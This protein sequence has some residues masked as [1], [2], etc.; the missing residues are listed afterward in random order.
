MEL[1]WDL[2]NLFSNTDAFY[3]EIEL[4]KES[5]QNISHYKDKIL[6]A[7]S[8]FE[9]L[10]QSWGIKRRAN[11]ILVYGS[12]R[13]YK[14]VHSEECIQMKKVAESLFNQINLTLRFVDQKIIELG[15]A[16]IDSFFTE[17]AKLATY[18][19]VINNLLRK[20][21]HVP[22]HLATVK[23]NDYTNKMQE[24][25]DLYN[26]WLRDISYGTI[27]IDDRQVELS[28][29][30]V[31]KYLASRDRE[32]RKQTYLSLNQS[33]KT[34]EDD[35][36]K[37]LN[38]L[39]H[40][41]ILNAQLENYS[42]V[43]EKELFEENIDPKIIDVLIQTVSHHLPLM[44][45]YLSLKGSYLQIDD[46]HLY[47]FGVPLDQKEKVAYTL[48]EAII[49]ILEALKPLGQEYL[50]VVLMLLNGHVDAIPDENKHQSITFSWWSYSFLNFKGSYGDLKNLIHELGHIV[51]YY[52][53]SKKQ[54]FP[55]MDSTVFVG[56]TA[57]IVNEILLNQY[58]YRHANSLEEKLFYLSKEIE[59]FV[60]SVFKQ[61][62]YTEFENK[63]YSLKNEQELT[64]EILASTYAQLLK[65]YYGPQI[66]CDDLAQ[67]EWTRLGKLYR[68]SYY[69][70][71]Y[72]TG[73]LIASAVVH[74][75]NQKSLSKEEY[76]SFLASGSSLYSLDLLKMLHI[77]FSNTQIIEE[78]FKVME[79]DIRNFESLLRKKVN[80]NLF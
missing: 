42:S 68:W 61:T 65:K 38:S 5:V 9:L 50:D 26:S 16:K 62:M 41:K 14:N 36:A 18:S 52:L 33:F 7:Q 6:N 59:N 29:S 20:Q 37:I 3:Q 77:D 30:N 67:I 15:S 49:I 74:S 1:K 55:Y 73:L 58:L 57:S 60:T 4:V 76:L 39:F 78:G 70:Y 53:S 71:K 23:I 8:L 10:N 51:N 43:L 31:N 40:Y 27:E 25:L 11:T 34:Q 28:A 47:D 69:P 2:S 56:E 17:N 22:D 32:T 80:R 13:Y 44:Q 19:L 24:E 46:P 35:F 45:E 66:V 63:L 12:L 79:Q 64:P 72:A 21:K 54:A 75:L 48:E